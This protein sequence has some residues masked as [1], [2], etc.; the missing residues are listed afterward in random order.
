M[1]TEAACLPD[2]VAT[3]QQLVSTLTATI[4]AQQRELDQL[5]HYLARLLRDRYGPRSEK[6]DPRQL[7]LFETSAG[8]SADES[9]AE[10]ADETADGEQVLVRR[11][12]KGRGRLLPPH[13]PR[14]RVEHDLP[15]AEKLCPCCHVPRER[16]GEETSEQ[17]EYV[18]ASLKVLEH[19][20]YKYACKNPDCFGH[21]AATPGATATV[22]IAPAPPKPIDKGLP[23]PGLVAHL[24]VN[25]LGDHLPLYRQEDELARY[26]VEISRGTLCRWLH[27]AAQLLEPLYLLLVRRVRRS[28]VIHTD[29]TTVP[30]IDPHLPRTR[31]GRLWTYCG[32]DDQPYSV[33][34]YTAS[35]KRDGPAAFLEEFGGWLQADAWG[36]YDGIYAT[37]AVQQVSCWA[38]ARRKFFDARTVQPAEAHAA[39]A[40]IAR[41][42]EVER[43]LGAQKPD[44]F[45]TNPAARQA[46]FALRHAWRQEQSLAILAEFRTWLG[47]AQ[48]RVLPKSPVGQAI[49]YV[50]PRWESFVRYC[51][52]GRLAI[53][54]NL[55]ERT[56]RP[57]AIGRKNWLFVGHDAAGRTLAMLYSFIASAKR[58]ELEPWA[59]LRDAISA[60]A[61]LSADCD[62]A[63]L[64]DE[65]LTPL[66][67]DVWLAAHPE[68]HRRY[69]R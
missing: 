49:A 34:E 2:D 58:N 68:A 37:S 36:G 57:C 23:G 64:T 63:D 65:E 54:N 9:P 26:G 56:L 35:H 5:Q 27:Q 15:E 41:L 53:D 45:R 16:I 48:S 20:R 51:D 24:I 52:D 25:K 46:W 8:E 66:L 59:W 40:Y 60:L 11:R 19:V 43:A 18:P 44:D 30:V 55:S 39:L 33:Y 1:S 14:E 6:L 61:R 13:L 67:P 32:D 62:P 22:A 3:L 38:H 50:L 31:T 4:A 10:D 17:L 12:S 29:D 47:E 42:Y 69:S 28:A 7:G 21:L